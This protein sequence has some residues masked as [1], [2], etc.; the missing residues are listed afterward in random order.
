[1]GSAETKTSTTYVQ[2]TYF[3]FLLRSCSYGMCSI[4]RSPAPPWTAPAATF[5]TTLQPGRYSLPLSLPILHEYLS[6]STTRQ[7]RLLY[8]HIV[9][10][11]QTQENLLAQLGITTLQDPAPATSTQL[12]QARRLITCFALHQLQVCVYEHLVFK[13]NKLRNFLNRQT[14][15]RCLSRV[16]HELISSVFST[17]QHHAPRQHLHVTTLHAHSLPAGRDQDKDHGLTMMF[18][19]ILPLSP[20][21]RVVISTLHRL[22]HPCLPSIYSQKSRIVPRS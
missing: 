17:P 4:V 10:E 22:P 16:L 2:S 11:E 21:R 14:H 3:K 12:L 20:C 19:V 1:M 9:T 5:I 7:I 6:I 18:P 8:D 13:N 15:Q